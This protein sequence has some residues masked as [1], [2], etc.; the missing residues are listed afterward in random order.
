VTHK[1][2]YKRYEGKTNYVLIAFIG[3]V[4]YLSKLQQ[5]KVSILKSH[6]RFQC[7]FQPP[8]AI[9]RVALLRSSW[10][11]CFMRAP[12]FMM[13]AT[14]SYLVFTFSL[15]ALLFIHPHRQKSD[16]YLPTSSSCIFTLIENWTHVYMNS[17]YYLLLKHLLFL[18]KHPVYIYIHIYIYISWNES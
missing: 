1:K 11:S 12:L 18:L 2:P 10:C 9:V 3:Y 16:L 7:T 4:N 14:N 8:L 6:H 15:W 5:F 17:P 13:R